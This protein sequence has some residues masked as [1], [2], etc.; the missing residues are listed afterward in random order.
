MAGAATA[1]PRRGMAAAMAGKGMGAAMAAAGAA[2][3]MAAAMAAAGAVAVAGAS[4]GGC[5]GQGLL[6]CEMILDSLEG[7][8]MKYW[9][10]SPH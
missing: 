10:F 5:Y 2:A 1:T 6:Q 3:A 7:L 4:F 8:L 9:L